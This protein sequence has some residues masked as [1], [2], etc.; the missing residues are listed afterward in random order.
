M[1]C[2]G[3]K[4][5]EASF[6]TVRSNTVTIAEE[7][8]DD[9]YAYRAA[10]GVRSVAEMLAHIA[11]ATRWPLDLHGKRIDLFPVELYGRY[12]Q[13]T[14]AAEQQITTKAQI[15]AALKEEGDRFAA[16]LGSLTD[17]VLAQRVTFPAPMNTTKSRFE[18]LLSIKEHEMHHRSQLMLIERLLGIVPHLTRQ[19][20]AMM[21]QMKG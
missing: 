21:A 5:F 20:E 19:R 3:A 15:V 2:Y 4:E 8:P 11:M 13:E 10:P 14:M 12:M 1:S 17:E 7:I 18:M 16:F 6:R 9:K